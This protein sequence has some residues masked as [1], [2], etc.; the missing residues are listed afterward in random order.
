MT[1]RLPIKKETAMTIDSPNNRL[2]EDE[3]ADHYTD[4]LR[5]HALRDYI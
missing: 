1:T 5:Y 3:Q 4:N 2:S